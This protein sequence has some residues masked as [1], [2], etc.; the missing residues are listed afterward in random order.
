MHGYVGFSVILAGLLKLR[1]R[2]G[3]R[4]CYHMGWSIGTCSF[5]PYEANIDGVVMVRF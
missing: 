4:D 2:K 3:K 5:I 1:N